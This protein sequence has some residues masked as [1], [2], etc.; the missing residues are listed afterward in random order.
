M[1][2]TPNT[3]AMTAAGVTFSIASTNAAPATYDAAGFAALTYVAVAEVTN[4][5][6]FGANYNIVKHNP[7]A[8]RVTQKRKGS[9]DQ[10][11]GTLDMALINAD[12]GQTKM[13]AA[14]ADD[15]PYAVKIVLQDGTIRYMMMLIAG[16]ATKI[17][18]I[19]NIVQASVKYEVTSSIVEVNA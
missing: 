14:A 18:T 8:T 19:D 6:E 11:S 9:V 4:I 13:K 10:G 17:G 7:L 3:L 2:I 1:A 5:P 16:F 12:A 15:A